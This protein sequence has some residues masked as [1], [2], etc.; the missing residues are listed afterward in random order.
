MSLFGVPPWITFLGVTA[1]L[2]A[3]VMT[4]QVLDL[5][6]AHAGLLRVQPGLHPGGALGDGDARRPGLGRGRPRASTRPTSPAGSPR[7]W[8][9]ILLANI[10][11]T[12]TPWQIFFQQSAVVDKGLDIHD[13]KFGKID[14]FVGLV[15]DLHGGRLHHHRHGRGVLLPPRRPSS[16]RTPSRRPRP[17]CRSCPPGRATWR[18]R[19]FAIG[20]FDAGF[21]GALCISL[22]TS[23]ARGRGLRLGPLAQQER[24][25]RALVLCR[26]PGH[27]AHRGR[28]GRSSPARP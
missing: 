3:V 23:W 2:I 8:C 11:T 17:W 24:P 5:R 6:E 4:G 9:F 27:A 12:I 16:S 19:L 28:R 22:S 1:I 20:L 26:L 13:I 7:T 15:P 14:T 25:G 10:G 18:A 21:L